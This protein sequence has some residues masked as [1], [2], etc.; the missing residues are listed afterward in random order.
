MRAPEAARPALFLVPMDDEAVAEVAALAFRLRQNL[1]VLHAY[2]KRNL[3]KG[4]KEA[5]RAGA[6][7]A[8]LRGARERERGVYA[9]KDLATGEQLELPEGELAG[10]LH[11]RLERPLASSL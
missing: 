3:G 7:F 9:L 5:E 2:A 10:F 8:G 6:R 1:T 4:F 11:E